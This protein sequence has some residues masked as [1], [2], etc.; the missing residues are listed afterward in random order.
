MYQ[1]T[2]LLVVGVASLAAGEVSLL[3]SPVHHAS[4]VVHSPVHHAGPIVHSPVHHA[5]SIVHSPVHHAGPIV[6]SPVHH[7]GPIVHSPVHHAGPIVHSPKV[8]VPVHH[9]GVVKPVLHGKGGYGHE[10][11]HDIPAAYNYNYLIHDDYSG[12]HFGHD[13]VR[14]G[15]KTEGKYFVHLPDG[16]IQ[17]VTYYADETGYHA[18]VT[19]EGEAHYDEYVPK[20]APTYAPK[21][22]YHAPVDVYH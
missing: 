2:L 6:H 10:T 3:H 18:T 21:P 11:Y 5:G 7:A 1:A 8:H 17:T 19:Y 16:R 15:Y 22:A 13:E 12:A 4:P 9:G 14:D 20:H